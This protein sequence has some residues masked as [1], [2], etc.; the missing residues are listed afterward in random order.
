MA[1]TLYIKDGSVEVLFREDSFERILRDRLGNDV[2]DYY[3]EQIGELKNEID[4]LKS[5]I[6]ELKTESGIFDD[7]Q[8]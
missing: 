1:D 7:D 2:A 8:Y 5:D 3:V 6:N 4:D